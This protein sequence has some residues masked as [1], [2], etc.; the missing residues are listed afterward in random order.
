[1]QNIVIDKKGCQLFA[2]RNILLIQ[3]ASL[4]KTLSIPFSQ[5]QSITITTQVDLSSHLLTRL[6]EHQ[7]SVCVLP[8]GRTGEACFLLGSWHAAVERRQIQYNIINT[9]ASKSYWASTLVRLKLDQQVQ[10]LYTLQ[11]H[12]A[13][14]LTKTALQAPSETRTAIQKIKSLRDKFRKHYYANNNPVSHISDNARDTGTQA[15]PYD[16]YM[17]QY[18]LASILGTEGIGSAIYFNSYQSFFSEDLRFNSRNRR[19]PKDPVNVVLSL[20][21]TLLQHICQQ[22]VYSIGFDPYHGVLHSTSYGRQ[23]LACD[24]VELQRAVIDLWVWKL[25]EQDTLSLDDFSFSESN[26]YP[27]ELLK[28]GRAKYYKA[29]AAIRPNLNKN[30]LNHAWIWQRRLSKY[31]SNDN[32]AL[33]EQPLSFI[34]HLPHS[35]HPLTD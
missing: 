31:H 19:P 35:E 13:S 23:S 28:S 18:P 12:C 3:H 14:G 7:V 10:T 26:G 21:Y 16:C 29:F 33:V 11:Q 15:S 25:F 27:C 32:T 17:P 8:S 4:S 30:A 22:A 2:E 20:S 5:I 1:M 34:S 6:A 24:F 9:N